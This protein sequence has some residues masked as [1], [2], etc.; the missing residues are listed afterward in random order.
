MSNFTDK[1][2]SNVLILI[3]MEA[4]GRPLLDHLQLNKVDCKVP[5]APFQIYTGAYKGTNVTVV[6]N[7][8]CTRFNVDK[9]GT[10]PGK[11]IG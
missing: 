3:A 7:G 6:T 9:V 1:T 4:E 11:A 10:T 8:K 2:I 5:F